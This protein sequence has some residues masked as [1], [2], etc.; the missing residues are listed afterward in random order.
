LEIVVLCLAERIVEVKF[1]SEE[2]LCEE[3][4]SVWVCAL[5]TLRLIPPQTMG[6]EL[7]YLSAVVYIM[8]ALISQEDAFVSEDLQ[9]LAARLHGI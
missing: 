9:C 2:A 7:D 1:V 6:T 8:T 3:I 5:D 4:A